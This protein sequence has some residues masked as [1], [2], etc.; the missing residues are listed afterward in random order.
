[1]VV[2]IAAL[3]AAAAIVFVA[4]RDGADAD[5]ALRILDAEE[6]LDS[7][8]QGAESFARVADVLRQMGRSCDPGAACDEVREASAFASVLAVGVLECTLPDVHEARTSLRDY[9]SRIR[10]GEMTGPPA[11]PDC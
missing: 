7:T 3:A 10:S 1:M 2:L 11:L 4:T 6:D 8:A 5:D 9:V